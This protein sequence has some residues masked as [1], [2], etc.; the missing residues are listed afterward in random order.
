M[1]FGA[2]A[3]LAGEAFVRIFADDSAAVRGMK[4]FQAKFRVFGA[5]LQ[6]YGLALSAAGAA[7]SAPFVFALKTFKDVGDE[8]ATF[9]LKT[10]I[11]SD[12]A[13]ELLFAAKELK[14][15]SEQLSSGID[16]MARAVGEAATGSQKAREHIS[17]LGLTLD[18]L[19]NMNIDEQFLKIA[20]AIGKL[21]NPT[22]RVT[23]ASHFFGRSYRNILPLIEDGGVEVK[24]LMER[25]RELGLT[26]SV[27]DVQAARSFAMAMRECWTQVQR[28]AFV[29]GAS[30]AKALSGA[31]GYFQRFMKNLIESVRVHQEL[32][33]WV[34][35][36]G[37]A[38]TIVGTSLLSVAVGLK[39]VAL[40]FGPVLLALQLMGLLTSF[41]ITPLGLISV[42][43]VAAAAIFVRF[44]ESGKRMA[45]EIM[46]W[47]GMM[48]DRVKSLL[49]S[50]AQALLAGKIELAVKILW[51]G[52]QLQFAEGKRV[53][54][55]QVT[56]IT[57]AIYASFLSLQAKL[58]KVIPKFGFSGFDGFVD[59]KKP[60]T[61]K[62]ADAVTKAQA[63]VEAKR[64]EYARAKKAAVDAEE[65]R[66]KG[67]DDDEFA[68]QKRIS[69]LRIRISR[70]TEPVDRLKKNLDI[71]KADLERL[72]KEMAEKYPPGVLN[73]KRSGQDKADFER[74]AR[75]DRAR[76][77]RQQDLT[78]ELQAE[79]DD[80][81][82]N[83]QQNDED[84]KS[85][86]DELKKL[87]GFKPP[88][89]NDEES[90]RQA[91]LTAKEKQAAAEAEL[92]AAQ[93]KLESAQA[94]FDRASKGNADDALVEKIK[95]LGQGGD[96]QGVQ[97]LKDEL[98]AAQEAIKQDAAD[99]AAPGKNGI[100]D[101]DLPS[102]KSP[103]SI[104]TFN[105]LAAGG[106]GGGDYAKQTA[107]N[108]A[109]AIPLLNK[110]VQKFQVL[111]FS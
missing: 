82:G 89:K 110:L 5:S 2:S 49:A 74:Q 67:H 92:K 57:N 35:L 41:L 94:A 29:I 84:L 75:E 59:N 33:V 104:G 79:Y 55:R 72:R 39:V 48:A 96:D 40:A 47:F 51:L 80:R 12:A 3:I 16:F 87:E 20:D 60:D 43:L 78:D 10:G 9:A 100:G 23:A 46:S 111:Q 52:I 105:A 28:L 1:G 27:T 54:M 103:A 98:K 66:Q 19:K 30:L 91:E 45:K 53:L 70:L 34:G 77:Q 18:Q 83:K 31:I 21:E 11:A 107:V 38:L 58:S 90:A 42:A 36:L 14:V 64:A 102:I 95:G 62:E 71:N 26:L 63:E 81:I 85:A 61:S 22:A 32:I 13:S 25:S 4:S 99:R 73:R 8:V 106:L 109:A 101:F 50:V 65:K 6:S 24:R 56:D 108:T 17:Q 15:T 37:A 88:T 7:I 76:I 86:R 68:R 93:E 97:K 44:T 69:E